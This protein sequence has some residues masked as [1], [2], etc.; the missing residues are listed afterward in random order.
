MLTIN[1]LTSGSLH[2]P[3]SVLEPDVLYLPEYFKQSS[4]H[5]ERYGK[6]MHGFFEN[7]ISWDYAEPD[8]RSEPD[9]ITSALV[10]DSTSGSAIQWWI[11]N[12]P[13]STLKMESKHGIWM[14]E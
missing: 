9:G 5:I 3:S 7:D 14:T 10:A 2:R 8:E 4:Y 12:V 11:D 6:I 1:K 13:D